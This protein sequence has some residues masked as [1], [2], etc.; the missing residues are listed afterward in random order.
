MQKYSL[1]P[2]SVTSNIKH[3]TCIL[4]DDGNI[5]LAFEVYSL[6]AID[7]VYK[8]CACSIDNSFDSVNLGTFIN[9]PD[10]YRLSADA[11][12]DTE[13]SAIVIYLKDTKTQDTIFQSYCVLNDKPLLDISAEEND[14]G[15]FN[16]V[17]TFQE[18]E[19]YEEDTSPLDTAQNALDDYTKMHP[20]SDTTLGINKKYYEK[21]LSEL[22]CFEAFSWDE[23]NF[24]WFKIDAFTV[25][26]NLSSI[27]YVLFDTLS[28][29]AFDTHKHY[30]FGV[31]NADNTNDSFYIAVALPA[32][33]NPLP[34]LNGYFKKI[35]YNEN[36]DYYTVYI[37]LAP[38]GQY[39]LSGEIEI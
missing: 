10:A 5:E 31:K 36:Y 26:S 3:G 14:L 35:P 1:I 17:C 32:A 28:I 38:D 21:L 39:F 33:S 9:Q 37:E 16:V 34:H 27:K 30:L 8:A 13:N 19:V 29:N 12:T 25:P 24:N 6:P 7:E 11:P 2:A 20:P 23:D 18:D 22:K 15:L 4:T